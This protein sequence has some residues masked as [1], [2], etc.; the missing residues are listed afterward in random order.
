MGQQETFTTSLPSAV[1]DGIAASLA[2]VDAELA[3]R[4]P[5]DPGTRQ[6]VHTVYVPADLYTAGT[7]RDWGGQAL[8]ALDEHAPDAAALAAVLGIQDDL[9]EPVY[10]RM[11]AKLT[12][13]PIED[14]RID[15]EDGYGPRPD[16]EEDAAAARAASLV[17][18]A[19]AD[20]TAPPY[21]GI[22]MK[23]MEAAVRD[24]GIRT[25]D[26]FLT[27]LMDAGG[28]PGGLV[29]TLPKVTYAEQVTA[30][31]RLCEAF[32]RAHG[33]AAGRIGFEIQIETTQA[34]LGPD[35]RAT[36]A[37]M[38]DAAEGR[39]TGLHYGT[40][41]YSASCGVSAAHQSMDHPVADHAKAVMQ[42]AA[43]GTGVRLSDGSTNVLPVGSSEQVHEAWRLHHRLVRRS[44]A[45]AYYQ[46]W[47][48][49][50]GHLPTRYAAVYGFYR[51]G[52]PQA[53]ARLAAYVDR[54][55]GAG[56]AIADEPA[57]AKALSGYLLRG[58][59][60]GAVDGAEVER[61]TGLDRAALNA[62][63]GRAP[64]TS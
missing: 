36:V 34:I 16:A 26:I 24:R 47:D 43:A 30:M 41:D 38:I 9:A 45:R 14:L 17:A 49:H 21:I 1:R 44:L 7:V 23:C 32:E 5:G 51:D 58:L 8:A 3:R 62:L 13:E 27:G 33:L 4:Y 50:P 10:A 31:V 15:F 12:R 25:L 63:S 56:G 61:L 57:T 37:R 39:A 52:L 20:G 6:P 18:A 35:G 22:R 40:F 46:G 64:A 29:L 59:D 54:A 60:C 53:A 42:V 11:R 2:G 55:G 28:L 19:V 48:M